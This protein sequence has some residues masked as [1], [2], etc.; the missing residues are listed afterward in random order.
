MEDVVP[1]RHFE[2]NV[3]TVQLQNR[4]GFRL[5]LG[6]SNEWNHFFDRHFPSTHL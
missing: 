4:R 2:A 3:G 6:Q 5:L 1:N